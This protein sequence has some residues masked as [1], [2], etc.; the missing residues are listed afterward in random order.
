[1][2]I[3]AGNLHI[4]SSY[5]DGSGSIEEV[6][7][8]A[9]DAG[10]SF[11][12]VTDHRVLTGLREEAFI[13]GVAVL[14]G[15]ELNRDSN[16]YLAFGLSK[17][18]VIDEDDPQQLID[19]V[20]NAGALGFLA[21]PFEKGSPY[22][23]KGRC[24][25]WQVWPV[26]NF[27][28]L[29]IWNYSSHWRGRHPSLF[30]TLY[31]F[32]LNRKAAMDGPP[33]ELLRL[34]DCYNAAGYKV[35]AIGSTDAHAFPYQLG[36]FKMELFPYAYL[37][38]TINTYICLGERLST[39]F[40]EAKKQIYG[41]LGSG[42][43]YISFDSLFPGKGFSFYGEVKG[44]QV[45]MGQTLVSPGRCFLR[46]EAP[47]E[48]ALLRLLHNGR[49]I[50]SSKGSSLA[51]SVTEPGVYRAEAFFKP[52]LGKARPWIYSNPIFIES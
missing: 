5:S 29:E 46:I 9:A 25:P 12:A 39:N 6:A 30:R 11:I 24:Y 21:H 2:Y 52:R 47:T 20:R 49:V 44:R 1:M 27:N 34:W 43:C 23:E 18:P 42:S 33:P 8:A 4:H 38:K 26:F 31:Y 15:V 35:T 41:A 32:F 17:V 19:W 14:V 3:Y 50:E 22:I 10:L 28:G 37:F 36:P 16:H 7:A 13:N 48:R 51:I 45:A 40:A